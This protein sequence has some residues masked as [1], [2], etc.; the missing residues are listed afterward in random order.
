MKEI[1]RIEN[2]PCTTLDQTFD[3]R[4]K[5]WKTKYVPLEV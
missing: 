5:A 1:A 4:V 2:L 3:D